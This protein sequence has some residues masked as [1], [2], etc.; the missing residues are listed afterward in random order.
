MRFNFSDTLLSDLDFNIEKYK[1]IVENLDYLNNIHTQ[2]SES[3]THYI[4]ATEITV[5]RSAM[6]STFESYINVSHYSQPSSYTLEIDQF[7]KY[8]ESRKNDEYFSL[9]EYEEKLINRILK[10]VSKYKA[11]KKSIH[12][13][14][15]KQAVHAYWLW[16]MNKA[17]KTKY[18]IQ[19]LRKCQAY[20]GYI[21]IRAKIRNMM[22]FMFK[23]L[24][25][26]HV[27]NF[28]DRIMMYL[29]ENF[30]TINHGLQ[31]YRQPNKEY[32]R[33]TKLGNFVFFRC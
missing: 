16:L 2:L 17:N 1:S 30:K 22:H 3:W 14:S 13:Y 28:Q 18:F 10:S 12:Y 23:N 31:T 4:T 15:F 20:L 27:L 29:F 11:T 33:S 7:E 6:L 8:Y 21:D 32:R 19:Y 5:D 9:S 26:E 24:D 25:D